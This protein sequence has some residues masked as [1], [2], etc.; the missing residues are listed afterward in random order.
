MSSCRAYVCVCVG[1]VGVGEGSGEGDESP[2]GAS[3]T[4]GELGLAAAY[5]CLRGEEPKGH[6]RH[7]R[8]VR[9]RN[10][11]TDRTPGVRA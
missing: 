1:G 5:L 7:E 3:E 10:R 11:M 8:G 4:S 2:S 9:L 6:R